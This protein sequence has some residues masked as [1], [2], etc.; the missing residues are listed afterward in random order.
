MPGVPGVPGS[1]N[2]SF[3]W[4]LPI[5]MRGVLLQAR[6]ERAS[7]QA[8]SGIDAGSHS[9]V[10]GVSWPGRDFGVRAPVPGEVVLSW[11]EVHHGLQEG[12]L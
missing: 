11:T 7:E 3:V 2:Q 9:Q 10:P 4:G 5:S 1:G 12:L 8:A 6:A